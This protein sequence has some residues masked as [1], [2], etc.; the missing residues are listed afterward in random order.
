MSHK[1]VVWKIKVRILR[2]RRGWRRESDLS[3]PGKCFYWPF[4]GCTSFVDLL[5]YLFIV[6]IMLSRLFIAALWSTAGK[7]LTSWLWCLIVFLSLIAVISWNRCGTWL[8]QFLIFAAFLTFT[9]FVLVKPGKDNFRCLFKPKDL[10]IHDIF[11]LMRQW[12]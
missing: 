12:L 3:P 2:L 4:Q 7:G 1:L 6:F 5:F 9:V 11:N 8:Y 10:Y